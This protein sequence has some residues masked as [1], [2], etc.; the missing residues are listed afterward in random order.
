MSWLAEREKLQ[1]EARAF[2]KSVRLT[3]K[4]GWFWKA[5]AWVLFILS[6]GKFKR[7]E[8]LTRF[9]TTIGHIQAYPE[10]WDA[11]TVRRVMVHES[12]HTFQARI[13][14]LKS[15]PIIGLPIM[16][17]LYGFL[18]F[19][20]LLAFCRAWFELDADRA[21]WRHQLS[22]GLARPED[23]RA[24]ARS[25]AETI[26]GPAYGWTIWRSLAIRWFAHEAEK[27]ISEYQPQ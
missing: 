21:S 13:C 5:I 22:N 17:L 26:S 4:N 16:G 15:H 20:T 2:D 11:G 10:G 14:G 23:I 12:R 7:E 27:V 18:L 6:F 25:F 3:T 24:R 1:E 9:A 19:P 8:F